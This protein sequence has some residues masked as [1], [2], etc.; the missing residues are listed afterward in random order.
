LLVNIFI[1]RLNKTSGKNIKGLSKNAM[2]LFMNYTWPGNVREL[3][4]PIEFAFV[5]TGGSYIQMEHIPQKIASSKN[6]KNQNSLNSPIDFNG[7][8]VNDSYSNSNA[9]NEKDQLLL[10]LKKT[11]TSDV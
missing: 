8:L 9:L 10:A 1:Q 6:P 3:K 2:E 5:T 7:G 11:A 4:N